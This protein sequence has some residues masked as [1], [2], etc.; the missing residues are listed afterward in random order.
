ME[1][2]IASRCDVITKRVWSG[3]AVVRAAMFGMGE[4]LRNHFRSRTGTGC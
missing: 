1:M 3:W 4:G 2:M